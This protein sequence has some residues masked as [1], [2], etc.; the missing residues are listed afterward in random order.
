MILKTSILTLNMMF[1]EENLIQFY[2]HLLEYE[3]GQ[4]KSYL[5][6]ILGH[7]KSIRDFLPLRLLTS[8]Y[9]ATLTRCYQMYI[10]LKADISDYNLMR[11]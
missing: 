1:K 2:K 5:L 3:C 7:I 8:I 11:R 4:L 6:D 10:C 9:R